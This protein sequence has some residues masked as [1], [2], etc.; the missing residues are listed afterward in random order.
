MRIYV[1]KWYYL[2]YQTQDN[3]LQVQ[4]IKTTKVYDIT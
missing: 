4:E 3:K 1:T 2:C